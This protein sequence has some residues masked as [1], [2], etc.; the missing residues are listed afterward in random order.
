[1]CKVEF[2]KALWVSDTKTTIKPELSNNLLTTVNTIVDILKH[3]FSH[4]S[5]FTPTTLAK[6]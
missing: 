2:V 6:L 4:V 5:L 1:M 3:A